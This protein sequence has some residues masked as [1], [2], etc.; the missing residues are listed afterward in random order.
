MKQKKTTTKPQTKAPI[1]REAVRV[2]A[3]ELGARQ[4]ARR[5]GVQGI[6]RAFLGLPN[7]VDELGWY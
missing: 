6:Y 3:I 7:D 4:A 2:L 5:L 1:D